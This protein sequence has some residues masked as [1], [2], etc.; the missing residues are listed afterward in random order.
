MFDKTY[1]LNKY[2]TYEDRL[3][4]NRL[5]ELA[6][7]CVSHYTYRCTKFLDPRQQTIAEHT[8][9]QCSGIGFHFSG[10]VSEEER[11][12]CIIYHE[13]LD[14]EELELPISVL[15]AS[16]VKTDKRLS[17]R[18]IL[19][20][21][22]GSGIKRELIGDIILEEQ[23]AYIICDS[24]ISQYLL[25]NIN[26]IGSVA[27]TIAIAEE[28]HAI[29]EKVK[30]I[31]STVAS[32][33]LDSILGTGFGIS[34]AKAVDIIKSGKVRLNW[35]EELTPAREIKKDDV[36]SLR[37]KGRIVLSDISGNTKKDRIKITIKKFM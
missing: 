23:S 33:R 24:D 2:D 6:G 21:L 19:G 16:W 8:L 20:S 13:D 11:K 29:E 35:E 3:L 37:G 4:I 36:I 28:V 31:N 30:I 7:Q 32:L 27:V 26:K 10:G 22:M 18:D 15:K 34:R 9:S 14:S 25:Y 17:H 12:I 1:L 5:M